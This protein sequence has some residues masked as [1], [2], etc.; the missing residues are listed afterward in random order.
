MNCRKPVFFSKKSKS[1]H[2]N[3]NINLSQKKEDFASLVREPPSKTCRLCI[4]KVYDIG[5][6]SEEEVKTLM[7]H[8]PNAC[9]YI[10]PHNNNIPFF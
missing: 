5:H 10:D 2:L 3:P 6:A 7:K 1:L 8:H 9:L 4:K